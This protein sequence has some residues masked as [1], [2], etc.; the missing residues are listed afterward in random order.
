ML[1]SKQKSDIFKYSKEQK[2][3][4]VNYFLNLKG[5]FRDR[6]MSVIVYVNNKDILDIKKI[7]YIAHWFTP[8]KLLAEYVKS[9]QIDF[10]EISD[11]LIEYGF[12]T[13]NSLF[14]K[15]ED[16]FLMDDLLLQE[17][18]EDYKNNDSFLYLIF[19]KIGKKDSKEEKKDDDLYK[20]LN[21]FIDTTHDF[22]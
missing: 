14:S 20:D 10:N 22:D 12:K 3:K 21:I 18:W 6:M 11:P 19:D 9:Q 2:L 4:V 13:E 1:T 7:V 5:M 15:E 17:V 8:L 16:F